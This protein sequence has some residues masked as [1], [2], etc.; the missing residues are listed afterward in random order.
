MNALV[1]AARWER[2][3]SGTHYVP[4]GPRD[5]MPDHTLGC[6]FALCGERTSGFGTN[7]DEVRVSQLHRVCDTCLNHY[8]D[9]NT[10]G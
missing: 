2:S 7:A 8:I 3:P 9:L 10:G 5:L 1:T 4:A 6:G